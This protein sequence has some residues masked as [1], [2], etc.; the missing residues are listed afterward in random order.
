VS[1]RDDITLV[2]RAGAA[3]F[4]AE[5]DPA[6]AETAVCSPLRGVVAEDGSPLALSAAGDAY[7]LRSRVYGR[8]NL[9]RDTVFAYANVLLPLNGDG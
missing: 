9:W 8:L 2:A 4:V 1:A 3:P 6:S 5:F 7:A